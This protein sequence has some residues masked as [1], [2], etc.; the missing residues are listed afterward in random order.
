MRV[1]EDEAQIEQLFEHLPPSRDGRPGIAPA[2]ERP[3]QTAG[4][5]QEGYRAFLADPRNR[6]TPEAGVAFLEKLWRGEL[7][8]P[9]STKEL[10]GL[11]FAQITPS[12]LRAGLPDGVR[13]ADKTG[14]S[15]EVEGRSAA[16]NDMGILSWPG[17]HTVLVAAFLY[18]CPAPREERDRWFAEL[19]REVAGRLSPR[20]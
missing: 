2:G 18:D 7:L 14:T 20:R 1:D 17:G 19:A 6:S 16:Y 12:R 13:L 10:L 8:S 15:G 3:A 9:R 4:R 5:L 11:M